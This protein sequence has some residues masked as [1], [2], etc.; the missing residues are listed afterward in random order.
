MAYIRKRG[1][2]WICEVCIDRQRKSKTFPTKHEARAWADSQE[3]HGILAPHT[4]SE[5]IDKYIPIAESHK[6]SQAELSRLEAIRKR[7]G[8]HRLE[9][10]KASTLSEW[11]D[12]RLKEVSPVS[13]R[14]EMIILSSMLKLARREWGWIRDDPLSG[15]KKPVP[16]PSRRRGISQDEIDQICRNLEPMRVGKQVRCMFLLSIET[17]MRLGELL[18]LN[19]ADVG[20]K[21]VLL[22]DTKNGDT[23][24]VPLS[25]TARLLISE[26]RD[27]D[28]QRVFTL[29]AHQA[30]KA[31]QRASINGTHFHDARSEAITRLAKKL[32]ILE[33]ARTVG[34]RD[35][36]SL[37]IYF[38][39]SAES[40]ADKLA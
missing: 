35:L 11:R 1:A 36:K 9:S 12:A 39:E 22:R 29:N 28:P 27:I 5:A 8:H 40:I 20:D 13:V 33:L 37:M 38:A 21:A 16:G 24:K 30:S 19:W 7:L 3:S 2:I 31:F 34:H 18:S 26:R 25:S 23:R 14:R 32:T 17:A 10:L 15:V 6:G 4:I